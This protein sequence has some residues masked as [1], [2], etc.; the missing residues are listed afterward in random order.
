MAEQARATRA[1]EIRQER[2]RKPGQTVLDGRKLTVDES[3]LDRANFEYRWVNDR[4]GR[5][6]QMYQDD[7]DQVTD[8][9]EV[10][11]AGTVPTTQVGVD[12]GKPFNA[13]LMRKRKDWY[14]DDQKEKQKPLDEIDDSIRRGLNH[15]RTEPELAGEIAYT[16]GGSNIVSR[17]TR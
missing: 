8:R 16:P 12:A 10:D 7:W 1:E 9:A 17:A 5:V 11:A 15:E 2:R 14:A 3:R 6:S 13:V 4:G